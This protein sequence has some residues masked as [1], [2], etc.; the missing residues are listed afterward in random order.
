MQSCSFAEGH[1]VQ[2]QPVDAFKAT[3]VRKDIN[4]KDSVGYQF[5][6]KQGQVGIY[7]QSV[8]DNTNINY[9]HRNYH[10]IDF[11]ENVRNTSTIVT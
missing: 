7:M 1:R 8:C 11:K 6:V 3:L 10:C 9:M 5:A 2:L 4:K